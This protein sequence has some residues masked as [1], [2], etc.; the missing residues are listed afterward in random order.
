M[1]ADNAKAEYE[2]AE[3]K[4]VDITGFTFTG[5][6]DYKQKMNAN[7]F[8]DTLE[9]TAPAAGGTSGRTQTSD[10]RHLSA[11]GRSFCREKPSS[12]NGVMVI[13]R[14]KRIPG[15]SRLSGWQSQSRYL[16]EAN[17]RC[18]PHCFPLFCIQTMMCWKE[19]TIRCRYIMCRQEW[20]QSYSRFTGF[21]I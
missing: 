11:T 2:S 3:R 12:F 16:E 9:V 4:Y 21:Q 5:A 18:P 13:Q 1:D 6:G 10:L 7:L 15:G 8:K 19:P 14:Q 20:M 17:A